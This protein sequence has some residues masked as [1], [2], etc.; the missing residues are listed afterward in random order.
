MWAT[1]IPL[2]SQKTVDGANYFLCR[3]AGHAETGTRRAGST[4]VSVTRF[5]KEIPLLENFSFISPRTKT[6]PWRRRAKHG[7]HRRLRRGTEVKRK[8]VVAHHTASA[9][10]KRTQVLK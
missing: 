7:D 5:T 3:H 9:I 2:F 1:F 6:E 4:A 8:A 10:N